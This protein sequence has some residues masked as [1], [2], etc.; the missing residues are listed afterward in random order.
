M[1]N[2]PY[3]SVLLLWAYNIQQYS[4]TY[5]SFLLNAPHLNSPSTWKKIGS[6]LR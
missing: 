6:C 4:G 5:T 1:I 2:N 3:N